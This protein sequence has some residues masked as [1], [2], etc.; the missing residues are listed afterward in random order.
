MQTPTAKNIWDDLSKR[1]NKL[2]S[3]LR[4]SDQDVDLMKQGLQSITG[5]CLLLGVTP[6]L[7]GLSDNLIAVDNN[8]LMIKAVWPGNH[9]GRKVMQGD[10]LQLPFKA[11]T[12][13]A[14]IGD[15]SLVLLDYPL[16]YELLFGQLKRVLKN[17]GKLVLRVFATP[18]EGEMCSAVCREALEGKIRNIH[19][20]KWRL[21]M[22]LVSESGNPNVKVRDIYE[23]FDRFYPDR[24]E[25]AKLTLWNF[26]DIADFEDYRNSSSIYCFPRLSDVRLKY[27]PYFKE[28]GLLNGTYELSERCPVLILESSC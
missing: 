5:P 15:G 13:D 11:N 7:C 27:Q 9:E 18:E 2:T 14:V 22:A 1:W 20:F 12:F 6:E 17:G 19:V 23:T 3:P 24:E 10:W 16:S 4:P 8:E 25:L 21:I 26:Q 28:I